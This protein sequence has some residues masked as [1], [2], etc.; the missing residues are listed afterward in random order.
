VKSFPKF[1][2]WFLSL[3]M[4]LGFLCVINLREQK[5]PAKKPDISPPLLTKSIFKLG[6]LL[7]LTG[8]VAQFGQEAK[9]GID[10]ALET[11][12]NGDLTVVVADSQSTVTGSVQG[13]N[14][15]IQ[16]DKVDLV[17]GDI[18]TNLTQGS[19][20]IAESQKIPM[21][22][23]AST[24]DGITLGKHYLSRICFQD[25]FQGF[26]MGQF[27]F[28]NLHKTSAALIFDSDNDY[29]R[30]IKNAF[31][32]AFLQNSGTKI[33]AEVA[34]SGQTSD[35]MSIVKKVKK[36]NPDVVFIPGFP[37]QINSLLNELKGFEP[38]I[39][40][41][42]GWDSPDVENN[43]NRVENV[44]F[45]THFSSEDSDKSVVDFL[46]DF[47]KKYGPNAKP[48]LF[49]ALG[50]DAALLAMDSYMRAKNPKTS[51]NINSAL[52]ETQNF[53]GVTGT[54]SLDADHNP[55]KSVV[56][57]KTTSKGFQF[58]NRISPAL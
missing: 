7:P 58:F 4:V 40:G 19:S 21:L 30:G 33:V 18:T 55:K 53:K 39:L 25:S 51:E 46:S 2:W 57:L 17:I 15:L 41:A 31:K 27:A 37:N 44:Y 45:S 42:D 29:S 8:E 32:K 16:F 48:G 5:N 36:E 24:G 35:F 22:S 38:V 52:L 13:I 23:P 49:A 10:L 20:P 26:V 11:R 14:K 54:L 43:K 1:W 56:I 50:Y 3:L 28:H 6:L 9:K 34:Y 47:K 12:K